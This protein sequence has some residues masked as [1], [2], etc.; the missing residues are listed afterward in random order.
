MKPDNSLIFFEQIKAETEAKWAEIEPNNPF[1]A[2]APGAKWLPGL[3]EETLKAFET[4]IGFSFPVP[5]RNFYRT[6]NGLDRPY[7]VTDGEGDRQEY[8]WYY[9][10][11]RDLDRIRD[12]IKRVYD[13]C[14]ITSA[15][16][17]ARGISRIFPVW[18]HRFMMI[19]EPGH[20]ILSMCGDDIVFFAFTLAE[21]CK[22]ELLATHQLRRHG[23]PTVRFWYPGWRKNPVMPKRRRRIGVMTKWLCVM[24]KQV[25]LQHCA[26]G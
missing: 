2:A 9:S 10:Y 19:D 1:A 22:T 12:T 25:L 4:A 3:S 18:G 14:H 26:M 20:P 21:L 13:S 5:L 8:H 11:P 16:G 15:M 17:K 24:K 7:I 6:M 23:E